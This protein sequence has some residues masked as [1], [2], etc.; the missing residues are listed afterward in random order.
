MARMRVVKDFEEMLTELNKCHVQYLIVGG[1]AYIYHAKP[2]YTKG[3]DIWINPEKGNI[4]RANKA[5][6]AFGSPFL[7]A[8]EGKS[9]VVQIGVAPNRIDLILNIEGLTFGEAWKRKIS[10]RYGRPNANWIDL[11]NL[12]LIKKKID[13]PRHQED[14]RILREVKKLKTDK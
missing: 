5:L 11:D 2:R 8:Q 10:G 1:M 14:V 6:A 12:I 13:D 3:I 9:Q 4:E 7:I